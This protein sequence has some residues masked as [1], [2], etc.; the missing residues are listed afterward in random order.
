M[1]KTIWLSYDLGI[2]GDYEGMYNWLDRNNAEERG[3]N[4]ALIRDYE[5]GQELLDSK[6]PDEQL[7]NYI[8]DDLENAVNIGKNDRIYVMWKGISDNKLKGAFIFGGKKAAPWTG[9]YQKNEGLIDE[10]IE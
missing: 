4:L 10:E 7:K 9:F 3:Q 2:K 1:K 6:N 8:K 5:I